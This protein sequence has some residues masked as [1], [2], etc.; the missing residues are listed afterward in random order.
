[1]ENSRSSSS[2]NLRVMVDHP[3]W[4]VPAHPVKGLPQR[5]VRVGETVWLLSGARKQLISTGSV[6]AGR[7]LDQQF[8]QP[9]S[10]QMREPEFDLFD[11]AVLRGSS[12][13]IP[14]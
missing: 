1:M 13:I 14:A 7:R 12:E 6:G 5:V 10:E 8:H 2:E 11:P 3:A 4:T 9:H